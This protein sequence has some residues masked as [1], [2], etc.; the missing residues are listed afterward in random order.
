MVKSAYACLAPYYDKM[1]QDCDYDTWSQYLHT[2]LLQFCKGKTGVD[3]GCG[4]GLITASLSRLGWN[5]FGVD[6]SPDM[7]SQASANAAKMGRRLLFVQGDMTNYKIPKK[8]DFVLSACD[9]VNYLPKDCVKKAFLNA[10]KGLKSGGVYLFDISSSSKL[11]AMDGSVFFDDGDDIT[12]L[13]NNRKENGALV[14]DI[15]LFVKQPNGMFLRKDERHTQTVYETEEIISLLY[16][17]GFAAVHAFSFGT[18]EIPNGNENRIQ[19]IAI[20]S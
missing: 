5:I 2:L 18:T 11:N 20:K 15:T 1:N 8:V 6:I 16:E 3:F 10:Y 19:F 17:A 4:T 9:G 13:W 7:L 12:L 14:M